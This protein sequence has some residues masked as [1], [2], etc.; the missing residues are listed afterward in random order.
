MVEQEVRGRI[1]ILVP[2]GGY[3]LGSGNSVPVYIP[4][5]NFNAMRAAAFK[6]DAHPLPWTVA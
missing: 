1:R 4:L 2:G 6:Y 3:C 5:A